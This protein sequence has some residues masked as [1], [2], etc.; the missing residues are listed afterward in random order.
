MSRLRDSGQI[1]EAADLILLI[2]RPRDGHSYP[3]P[4]CSVNT[5]G[6]AMVTIAK[7]RNTGTGSFICEFANLVIIYYICTIIMAVLL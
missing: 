1:E 3:E 2:Y 7:G 6:T 4:Y 5:D